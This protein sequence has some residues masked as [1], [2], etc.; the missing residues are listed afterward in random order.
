MKTYLRHRTA[1]VIDV[2]DLVA[3]EYLDFEGKY[4]NYSESH[5]FWEICYVEEKEITL[6]LGNRKIIL[7]PK[8]IV[9]IPPNTEHSYHSELGNL[10]KAFVICFECQSHTLKF[11]KE[12]VFSSEEDELY[13]IM[14]IIKECTRTFIMNENEHLEVISS[15]SFGGQQAIILQLEYMLIGLLRRRI[16]ER[17]TDVILLSGDKF[18]RDLVDI[19]IEYLKNHLGEKITLDKVCERFNYSRSFVCKIFK[20][21]TGVS[22]ITYI[23]RLKIDEAQRLLKETDMTVNE[24][25]NILGFSEAKYFG[26]V[27]KRQIGLSPQAYR[28]NNKGDVI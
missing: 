26:A 18:Y 22:L 8:D 14:K 5:D 17:Q 28:E 20:E 13:C 9:L 25:S 15:P 16:S 6:S 3:L 7:K 19:F 27:F 2:K 23:N 10:A 11:I 12:E 1:N 24:I 4:K 21:Q